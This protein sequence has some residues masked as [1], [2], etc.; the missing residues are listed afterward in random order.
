[1]NSASVALVRDIVGVNGNLTDHR[2]LIL[3]R[4]GTITVAL[5][6]AV[7]AQYAPSIIDGLLICYSIW[8]PSMLLPLLLGLYVRNTRPMA[9]WLSMLCGAVVSIIWQ[10]ALKEPMGIPAILVGLAASLGGWGF[11]QFCGKPVNKGQGGPV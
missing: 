11:G 10:T 4:A 9:G 8:A 5:I 3:G 6:A 2:Q 1:M 7:V